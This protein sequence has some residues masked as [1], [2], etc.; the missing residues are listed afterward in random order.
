MTIS[1]LNKTEPHLIPFLQLDYVAVSNEE[2]KQREVSRADSKNS[3]E[4][5]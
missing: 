2:G 5:C 3:L 4:F 1:K